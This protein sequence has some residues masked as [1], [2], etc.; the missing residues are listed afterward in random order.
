MS[1]GISGDQ[2]C[3]LQAKAQCAKLDQC[4]KSGTPA[5]Y[6]DLGTCIT[7]IHD[8][9]V[10]ALA[11]M[12]T[13]TT[14]DSVETCAL[15]VPGETC[16]DYL[17]NNTPTACL[18]KVGS[19]P[20]GAA[21]S[22][23]AQCQTSNC[24]VP[25]GSLCGTCKDPPALGDPCTETGCGINQVCTAMETCES[26]VQSG[27]MCDNQIHECAPGQTCV[28]PSMMTT[29]TCMPSVEQ[30]DA[31]CDRTKTTG[32]TCD[33]IAG[34]FCSTTN[35]CVAINYVDAGMI[36]GSPDKGVS[37]NLCTKAAA[38]YASQTMG[39]PSMC[40]KLGNDGDPCDIMLGPGCISPD[41][42]VVSGGTAGV[43]TRPDATK[44]M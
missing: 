43:C 9:C 4:R 17:Q 30:L 25:R 5:A 31:T 18:P 23:N 12:G 6:G 29:G 44:C 38:C 40:L 15:A 27:G 7:R 11:A 32:G 33:S 22:F 10:N 24:S 16:Q 14:P 2:A 21:C 26:W 1:S 34:L 35:K 28:I 8:N 41:R 37:E 39:M 19:L 36:C 42:C 13:G 3:T 20:T